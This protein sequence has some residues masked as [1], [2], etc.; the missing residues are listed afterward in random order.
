M[1]S[2]TRTVQALGAV[3]ALS[4]VVAAPASAARWPAAARA[5]AGAAAVRWSQGV[6]PAARLGAEP[7]GRCRRVDARHAACPIAI[8]VLVRGAAGR[9]PWRCSATLTVS[10]A[11]ERLTA[12]RTATRCSPLPRPAPIP[13][14]AASLG[15]AIALGA[16][17]DIACVPGNDAR[18]TCVL[19]YAARTGERCLRAASIPPGRPADAVA[20]GGPVCA[21]RSRRAGS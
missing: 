4:I 16:T 5:E 18:T 15:T 2:R 9:R 21:I 12:R 11:G 8:A 14:P 3:L 10:N 13:D 6:L 19:S 1:T 17:G 7:P 20:L